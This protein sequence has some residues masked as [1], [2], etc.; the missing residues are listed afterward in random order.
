M[1]IYLLGRHLVMIVETD[2]S[3]LRRCFETHAAKAEPE[4]THLAAAPSA[5]GEP[6]SWH[7][8][9]RGVAGG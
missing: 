9:S 2:G 1:E 3:D 5:F 4:R 7:F 6:R 8:G